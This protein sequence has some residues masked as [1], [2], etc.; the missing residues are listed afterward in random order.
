MHTHRLCTTAPLTSLS[1]TAATASAA[2]VLSD[3]W[4][5]PY[6]R[7]RAAY[8]A[9]WVREAK[10]WPTVSRVDNVYGDRHL[11]VRV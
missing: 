5:R 4:D 3:K 10:F 1:A 2:Q 11:V 8:P 9:P 6:S 7:E